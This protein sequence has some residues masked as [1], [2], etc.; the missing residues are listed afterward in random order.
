MWFSYICKPAVRAA[1]TGHRD[2][3]AGGAAA[4]SFRQG[5]F[6]FRCER[7][8][9]IEWSRRR[10]GFLYNWHPDATRA[11]HEGGPTP[12]LRAI[13]SGTL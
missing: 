8:D 5:L 12:V 10:R 2:R 1:A 9:P 13:A 3:P 7:S 6:V 4:A 11:V